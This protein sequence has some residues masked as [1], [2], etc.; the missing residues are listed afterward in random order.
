M[1]ASALQ[2]V[3]CPCVYHGIGY[4]KI[5]ILKSG[6]GFSNSIVLAPSLLMILPFCKKYFLEWIIH[7]KSD[8]VISFVYL[9]YSTECVVQRAPCLMVRMDIS[10]MGMCRTFAHMFK[11]AGLV[12]SLKEFIMNSLSPLYTF[13]FKPLHL[14]MLVTVCSSLIILS[15]FF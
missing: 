13:M 9:L 7:S 15:V 4:K 6:F 3:Y 8:L 14:Y 11:L 10:M 1:H 5:F 2:G 12:F